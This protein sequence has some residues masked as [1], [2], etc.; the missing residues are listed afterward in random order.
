M[1]ATSRFRAAAEKEAARKGGHAKSLDQPA[2]ESQPDL[3]LAFFQAA[4]K[5]R[6][7]DASG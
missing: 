3:A 4:E 2:V 5:F 6:E 1:M 7:A